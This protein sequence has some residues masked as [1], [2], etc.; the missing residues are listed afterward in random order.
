MDV[1]CYHYKIKGQ[2]ICIIADNIIYFGEYMEF[3]HNRN[4]S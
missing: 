3:S 4:A 2:L 1:L